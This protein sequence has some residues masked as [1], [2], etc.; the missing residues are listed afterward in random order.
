MTEVIHSFNCSRV[1]LIWPTWLTLLFKL[2][3]CACNFS[4]SASTS[5]H[6]WS[7][8][9]EVNS[10]NVFNRSWCLPSKATYSQKLTLKICFIEKSALWEVDHNQKSNPIFDHIFF[11][12]I[13][14]RLGC[15]FLR[16]DIRFSVFSYY[17]RKNPC[18]FTKIGNISCRYWNMK[19]F[20]IPRYHE[21]MKVFL[22][23]WKKKDI[24]SW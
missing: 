20:L 1:V 24:Y 14:I 2:L 22:P 8:L 21:K 11:V 10:T 18:S 12:K 23:L 16:P 3:S 6:V 15:T 13:I 9:L 4:C 5:L 17:H 19:I 7:C